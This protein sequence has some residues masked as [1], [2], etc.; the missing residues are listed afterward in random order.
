MPAWGKPAENTD[1]I[2]ETSKM[3]EMSDR[4]ASTIKRRK[5]GA[6]AYGGGTG[7][8]RREKQ[9]GP[10]ERCGSARG[11]GHEGRDVVI[12]VVMRWRGRDWR[13]VLWS[14]LTIG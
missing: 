3:L 11:Q 5:G 7:T 8:G 6:F 13:D 4:K 1:Y 14:N 9:W 2:Q 10:A 12:V